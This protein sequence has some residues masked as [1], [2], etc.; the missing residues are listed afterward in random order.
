MKFSKRVQSVKPSPTLAVTAR[1]QALKAQGIDVIGF[2]AG[3]PDFDTPDFIKKAALKA[4]ETGFT[5]YT[6]VGGI[7]ALKQAIVGRLEKDFHLTFSEDEV[8]VS[9]GG[10]QCLFNLFQALLDDGDEFL[11]PS[12]YWTSFPDMVLL[13]GGQPTALETNEDTGF[14]ITADQLQRAIGSRTRGIILNSP[15]NPTGA[16]YTAEELKSIGELILNRDLIV[17]SDDV[18]S[19]IVYPGFRFANVLQVCPE[20][21]ERTCI[22]HSFS[23]TYAM[24][25]WRIGYVAGSPDVI[26]ALSK[27]QDQSTSN[28]NSIAQKAAEAA[29]MGPQ[30]EV[31]NMVREFEKRRNVVVDRLNAIDGVSCFPP[32]GAFYVFPRVS[33]LFGRKNKGKPITSSDELTMALLQDAR[34]AVVPGEAFG[35][36]EHIRLSYATSMDQIEKG[37]DRIEDFLQSLD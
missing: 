8:M 9:A 15:S 36:K 35:S 13:A 32:G 17:V 16:V 22:V 18:Y 6:P 23:K 37:L 2:G 28:P 12:P 26:A 29:L 7:P 11:I 19:K 4:L 5:K 1:I 33:S 25:G 14:K 34:V 10:K 31:E 30:E 3:E 20:L 27:I 24:T 21:R